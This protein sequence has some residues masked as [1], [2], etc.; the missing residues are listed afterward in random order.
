MKNKDIFKGQK[1]G[2]EGDTDS[3]SLFKLKNSISI[4]FRSREETCIL[5]ISLCAFVLRLSNTLDLLNCLWQGL[6]M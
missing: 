6:T 2:T 1:K 5:E 3:V 4:L